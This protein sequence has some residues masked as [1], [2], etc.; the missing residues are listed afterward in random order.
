MPGDILPRFN[1]AEDVLVL[2]GKFVECDRYLATVLLFEDHIISNDPY[3]FSIDFCASVTCP[4]PRVGG[5]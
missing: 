4:D 5:G 2:P 3:E 1:F